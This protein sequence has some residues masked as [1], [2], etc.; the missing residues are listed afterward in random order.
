MKEHVQN[1]QNKYGKGGKG[2]FKAELWPTEVDPH[3]KKEEKNLGAC[4]FF[5][6]SYPINHS[7]K[8]AFP[9]PIT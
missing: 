6:L 9:L 1:F 2:V 5:F 8:P 7:P 4:F 3:L